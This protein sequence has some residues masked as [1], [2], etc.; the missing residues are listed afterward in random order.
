MIK[1][2]QNLKGLTMTLVQEHLKQCSHF[3]IFCFFV[4][5]NF[6]DNSYMLWNKFQ[7]YQLKFILTNHFLVTAWPII[8]RAA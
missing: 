1:K 4:E 3:Q 6:M 2:P 5:R 7:D 8:Y